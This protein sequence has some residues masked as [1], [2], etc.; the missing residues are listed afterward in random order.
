VVFVD[1]VC[2][3]RVTLVGR[4]KNDVMEEVRKLV[5][6]GSGNE[7]V[8]EMNPKTLDELLSLPLSSLT[9]ERKAA[10]EKEYASKKKEHDKISRTNV[11]DMWRKELNELREALLKLGYQP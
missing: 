4:N 1:A 9:V 7:Q 5:N 10:L 8:L 2:S 6:E 3:G 11:L